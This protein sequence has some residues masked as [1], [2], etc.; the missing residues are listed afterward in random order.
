MAKRRGRKAQQRLLK[1]QT[2]DYNPVLSVT[3]FYHSSIYH[4]RPPFYRFLHVPLMLADSRVRMAM[5]AYKG[6]ITSLARFYVDEGDEQEA[7]ESEIK[8]YAVR[9]LTRWWRN[10]ASKMLDSLAWGWF[11]GEPLYRVNN[12]GQTAFR[13]MREFRPMDVWPITKNGELVGIELHPYGNIADEPDTMKYH[14]LGGMKAFWHTHWRNEG[15]W[16][17]QSRLY[18]AFQPW[19]DLHK[20]G[21]GYGLRD[22]YYYR[23]VY[24]GDIGRYPAGSVQ[25]DN[26][27]LV[28][29]KDVMRDILEKARAG[30]VIGL[31]STRDEQSK[32]YLWD[33]QARNTGTAADD[34]R[35]YVKDLRCE[36]TE[37]MGIPEEVFQ[38]A[39]SGSGYSGRK[40]PEEAFRGM[41]TE[42]I[43]W[44]VNDFDEQ[45]LRPLIKFNFGYVPD[46]EIIP[47]G[48]MKED[49][50]ARQ[51][52]EGGRELGGASG[53]PVTADG[54]TIPQ[55]AAEAAQLK[56]AV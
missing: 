48:I 42:V 52:V 13:G 39:E 27:D 9:Q 53:D 43:F 44:M 3:P 41:L 29:S 12:L 16:W 55:K 7:N 30:E 37:G 28:A 51:A 49:F 24:H 33:I 10:S 20:Y 46:Y 25:D 45:I 2:A 40:I 56:L 22:K 23:H 11:A 4:H 50:N 18:G 54:K 26:G 31:P 1:T 34:I 36:M 6:T 47:F 14:Y 17:G 35:A 32:E 8:K 38:A 15:R 21:G 19:L 5:L